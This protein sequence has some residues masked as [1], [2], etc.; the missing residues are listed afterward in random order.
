MTD[1]YAA[2]VVGVDIALLVVG[3][4]E[5]LGLL[6]A[7]SAGARTL[8]EREDAALRMI[9]DRLQAGEEPTP[10]EL[11]AAV[12]ASCP[13]L[14]LPTFGLMA[15]SL[16]WAAPSMALLISVTVTV[17]WAATEAHGRIPL[18]ASY[19]AWV[20]LISAALLVLEALA[21]SARL[22]HTVLDDDSQRAVMGR[23]LYDEALAK[24]NEHRSTQG[25]PPSQLARNA[26]TTAGGSQQ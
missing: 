23:A 21:K 1:E 6:K 25:R 8:V 18:L 3:T 9:S 16:L 15:L 4:V 20:T 22:A 10:E 7:A 13:R 2:L 17:F 12:E 19:T 14:L 11:E 5:I 24:L 26:E